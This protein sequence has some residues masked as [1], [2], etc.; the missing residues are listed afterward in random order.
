MRTDRARITRPPAHI[1]LLLALF[2]AAAGAPSIPARA[3][4]PAGELNLEVRI[5]EVVA[6][7]AHPGRSPEGVARIEVVL[8]SFVPVEDV[9][10]EIE[11]PNRIS[12]PAE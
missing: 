5:V 3:S 11:K 9:R 8:Q 7:R 12:I 10:L 4:E 2:A 6:S 1:A